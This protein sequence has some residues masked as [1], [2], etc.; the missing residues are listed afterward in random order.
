MSLC[1]STDRLAF[2]KNQANQF[3]MSALGHKQPVAIISSERLVSGAYRPFRVSLDGRFHLNV[4]FHRKRSFN[5]AEWRP[6]ER[7]QSA[8]SGPSIR[9]VPQQCRR[10]NLRFNS[11]FIPGEL[12]M[13]KSALNSWF[14]YFKIRRHIEIAWCEKTVMPYV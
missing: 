11:R 10:G 4:C 9:Y 8:N 12:A 2:S 3:R 14:N 5:Q 13:V 1:N 7:L 6:A